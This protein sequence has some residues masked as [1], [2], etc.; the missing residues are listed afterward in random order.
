MSIVGVN[1]KAKPRRDEDRVVD[2]ETMMRRRLEA[3][4][5]RY[6]CVCIGWSVVEV[7][8]ADA[9]NLSEAMVRAESLDVYALDDVKCICFEVCSDGT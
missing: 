8:G 9:R 7:D 4:K 1:L 3:A 6:K 5:R 2:Y